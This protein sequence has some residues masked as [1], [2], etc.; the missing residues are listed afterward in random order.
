ML[1]NKIIQKAMKKVD[2]SGIV[3]DELGANCP[4]WTKDN[5]TGYDTC[6]I[7]RLYHGCDSDCDPTDVHC[8]RHGEWKTLV[9]ILTGGDIP[10]P[11]W[12]EVLGLE[13]GLRK[14]R[15]ADFCD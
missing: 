14:W 13:E 9:A 12:L 7:L 5:R 10:T 6:E 15:E 2:I 1:I 3:I 8:I 4:L 11:S